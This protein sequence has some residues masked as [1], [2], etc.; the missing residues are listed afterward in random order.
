MP[1][2]IATID[3]VIR[4][5]GGGG[6]GEVPHKDQVISQNSQQKYKNIAIK[7]FLNLKEFQYIISTLKSTSIF[8]LTALHWP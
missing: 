3:I 7:C 4:S 8:L 5:G 6:G 2:K 1:K